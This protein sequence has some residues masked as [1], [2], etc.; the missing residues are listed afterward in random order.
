MLTNEDPDFSEVFRAIVATYPANQQSPSWIAT[1]VTAILVP[2]TDS[3]F[4]DAR[5]GRVD[6][7]GI[8]R[9]GGAVKPAI[10]RL[11]RPCFSVRGVN[12]AVVVGLGRVEAM[13]WR[14]A[15]SSEPATECAGCDRPTRA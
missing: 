15:K 11:L 8:R 12:D 3:A 6:E 7:P 2:V 13:V 10:A 9:F 4:C 14:R 1:K 5:A